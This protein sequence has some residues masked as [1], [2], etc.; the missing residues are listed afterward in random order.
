ML[1]NW[2]AD[3]AAEKPSRAAENN[4]FLKTSVKQLAYDFFLCLENAR[5]AMHLL[6]EGDGFHDDC[7]FVSLLS[8][9]RVLSFLMSLDD[10]SPYIVR[11]LEARLHVPAYKTHEELVSYF[12]P[13]YKGAVQKVCG[14]YDE[15][16][17]DGVGMEIIRRLRAGPLPE[18]SASYGKGPALAAVTMYR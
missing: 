8:E 12:H 18:S 9:I 16:Y 4:L 17:V 10:N 1:K 15:F 5:I 11:R 6:L 14:A 7:I 13:A 3:A 2:A